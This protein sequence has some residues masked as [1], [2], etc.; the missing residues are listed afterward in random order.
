MSNKYIISEELLGRIDTLELSD[1]ILS[2]RSAVRE[3]PW[4]LYSDREKYISLV[5]LLHPI[6]PSRSLIAANLLTAS[7][8]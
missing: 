2:W 4:K 7:E 3:A 5:A 8:H 1:R 6:S